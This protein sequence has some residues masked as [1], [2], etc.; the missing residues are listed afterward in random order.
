MKMDEQ[1]CVEQPINFSVPIKRE[2][3]ELEAN[4]TTIQTD[5]DLDNAHVVNEDMKDNATTPL[6]FSIS[7]ILGMT[8]EHTSQRKGQ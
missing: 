1:D 7:N 4:T 5:T 2:Y 8:N 6:K 3:E